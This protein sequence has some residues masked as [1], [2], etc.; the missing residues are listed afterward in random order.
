LTEPEDTQLDDAVNEWA[1]DGA[2]LLRRIRDRH[3]QHE[4]AAK[5]LANIEARTLDALS[6]LTAAH[7]ATA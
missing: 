1:A 3:R 4:S 7:G 5:D 2:A 6:Q